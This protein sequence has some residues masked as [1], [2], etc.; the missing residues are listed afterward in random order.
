MNLAFAVS[1]TLARSD[2]IFVSN[3][4]VRGMPGKQTTNS[5]PWASSSWMDRLTVT[6]ASSEIKI[7]D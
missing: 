1:P 4:V 5:W 6:I 2:W 7:G 3:V